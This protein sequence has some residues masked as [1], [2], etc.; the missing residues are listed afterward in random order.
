MIEIGQTVRI[1]CI[2]SNEGCKRCVLSADNKALG[3]VNNSTC[4]I[5]CTP[6]ERADGKSVIFVLVDAKGKEKEIR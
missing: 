1:K 4:R 2:E 6:A 5:A 3:I